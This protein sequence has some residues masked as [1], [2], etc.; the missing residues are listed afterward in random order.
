MIG[1]GEVV[2]IALAAAD[3]DEK[4]FAEADVFDLGRE[5]RGH[6]A[7][8]GGIH[9]CLGA[10]LARMEGTIAIEQLLTR[11]PGIRLAEPSGR[12]RAS[13]LIRGLDRLIVTLD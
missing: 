7:F 2:L 13:I 3:R 9:Q 4:R 12:W 10:G 11:F 6:L 5:A 8:G 1:R